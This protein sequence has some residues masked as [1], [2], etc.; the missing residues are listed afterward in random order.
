MDLGASYLGVYPGVYRGVERRLSHVWQLPLLILSLGLF[1]FAAYLFIDAR[2]GISL[3]QK[4]AGARA[5]LT[6]DRPDAAVEHLNRL[7]AAENLPDQQV[8][9]VHLL[10][11][12]ALDLVEK[13]GA[14]KQGGSKVAANYLRI[15][16]QTQIALAKG[17]KPSGEIHR[18]LGE[19][20]EALSKPVEAVWQYRQAIAI[21]PSRALRLQRKV[22]DLQIATSDWAPA[23]ASIDAYLGANEITDAERAWAKSLKSQLL[24]DRGEFVEARRLLDDV[25][26]LDPSPIAQAE[27]RYRLGVCA[28]KLGTPSEA[29]K[30][31]S[32]AR[33]KFRGQHPLEADAAYALGRIAQEQDDAAG[34]IAQ[35]DAAIAVDLNGPVVSPARLAR[36]ACRIQS[37]DES[38]GLADLMA[39]VEKARTTVAMR[40]E[41][42]AALRKASERL[43][44]R[45]NHQAAIELMLAER[46][47][48]ASPPGGF[49]ARLG[50]TYEKRAEQVGQSI[51]DAAPGEKVRREQLA[52]ELHVKSGE[53]MLT[54]SRSLATA[55]DASY[56][57]PLWK[58]MDLFDRGDSPQ[59]VVAAMELLVTERAADP[60]A[61]DA[62]LRLG[63]THERMGQSEKAVSAYGRLRGAYPQ[64]PA[65]LKAAIPLALLLQATPDKVALAE[66]VLGDVVS[67]PRVSREAGDDYKS[68]LFELGRLEQ[69][70]GKVKEA[71]AH[72]G[73]FVVKFDSDDRMGEA[74][75]LLGECHRLSAGR[76]DVRIADAG[77]SGAESAAGAMTAAAA[78]KKEQLTLA[79]QRYDRAGEIYDAGVPTRETDKR[80]QKLAALRRAD[81]AYELGA[82]DQAVKLYDAV[83]VRWADDPV[84]LAASVQMVNAAF[85]MG[86]PEQAKAAHER[87]KLLLAKMP[88]AAAGDNAGF[89]M[90]KAYWEQW[91]KWTNLAAVS[92][93]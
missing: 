58:A 90:P 8:A 42:L 51:A 24:I 44:A 70:G 37:G 84:A 10:L 86:K 3:N 52:R 85:A 63:R 30:L 34:A 57:E 40:G 33:G 73:E 46:S 56:A 48:D 49:F 43:A 45:D 35:F 1:T 62:M 59:H 5:M 74:M 32:A 23:E 50:A 28:W 75:F 38:A 64:S 92:S 18:R 89:V 11:S 26:R 14:A 47:L 60:L 69:R 66:R 76:I 68:A 91:L 29:K 81:C 39:A 77:G 2:P 21:D 55:G 41:T 79:A 19:S 16:E 54:Y 72:L 25:L 15:I 27:A 9:Q 53:A 13:N 80:Y 12:E 61:A 31:L 88:Q 6:A 7:M 93:W 83:A 71:I 36:G 65:A 4:L 87:A 22:I 82:Y 78:A 67:D 20:Y 17:V